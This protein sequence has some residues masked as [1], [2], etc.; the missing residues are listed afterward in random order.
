M[1]HTYENYLKAVDRLATMRGEFSYERKRFIAEFELL[2]SHLKMLGE[3]SSGRNG[4]LIGWPR[5]AK[6]L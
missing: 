4:E 2:R 1:S 6:R 3:A 5:T